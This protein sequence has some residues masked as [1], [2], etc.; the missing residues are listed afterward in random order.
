MNVQLDWKIIDSYFSS[1]INTKY[2]SQHH[3]SSYNTF[4]STKLPYIIKTLNPY[5]IFKNDENGVKY[6]INVYIGGRDGNSIK[7]TKPCNTDHVNNKNNVM[8]PNNARLKDYSYASNLLVDIVIDYI[9]HN[10]DGTQSLLTYE[11]KDLQI[12]NIPVM[13]HSDLC[14]LKNMKSHEMI[15]IGECPYDQGGY[16][17]IDGKEKVIVSQE[18]VSTNK[19]FLQSPQDNVSSETIEDDFSH[20]GIIRCTSKENSLFPKTIKF[21]IYHS[22]ALYGTRFNAICMNVPNIFKEQIPIFIIFRALGIESD[23]EII[24][25]IFL[26]DENIEPRY[27][28]FIRK[29]VHEGSIVTTQQEALQYLAGYCKYNEINF[30]K[31]VLKTDVFPNVGHSFKNKAV[32]LGYLVNKMILFALNELSDTNR[33]SYLYKRVD[34]SGILMGN[35]FRDAYNQFRNHVK[36]RIDREFI[37]GS[38]KDMNEFNTIITNSKDSIFDKEIITSFIKKSFKGKWGIRESEGIVQDLNR[39]SFMGYISHIRRVNTPMDRSLKLVTPHRLDASHWG[40]MCPIE[41]PDGENIGLLKHIATSCQISEEVDDEDSIISLLKT[42]NVTLVQDLIPIELYGLT[43]V[44]LNNNWIGV[45]TDAKQLLDIFKALK[46]SGQ[47]SSH[48]S[49]SWN[50]LENEIE[51]FTDAGRC[52][53]PLYIATDDM[54]KKTYDI[55]MNLKKTDRSSDIWSALISHPKSSLNKSTRTTEVSLSPIEFVDCVEMSRS[56]IAMNRNDIIINKPNKY[57]HIEIHPSL[58]LSLNTNI[59]PLAHHNQSIRNVFSNQQ[60]KQAVGVYATNFNHRIDTASYMLHYPQ[61]AL[62]T[63]KYGK[64]AHVDKMPN[65]ENIIIAIATYTGYNQ[66]DSVIINKNSMARGMFNS[67]IYKS[68]IESE[69]SNEMNGEYINFGNPLNLMKKGGNIDVKYAKWDKIDENGIPIL[70]RYITE[71]DAYVGKIKSTIISNDTDETT[72]R[73]RNSNGTVSADTS[74]VSY[75]DKSSIA[76]FTDGGMIDNRIIYKKNDAK[77]IKIRFRKSRE[78]VLGDKFASRHGQKG[79]VGMII[80]QEDMPFTKDGIVPDMIINPHA[81]PSRMTIAH[82]FESVLAKYS[83]VHGD[84]IDGTT[85]ENIDTSSYFEF[86]GKEGY[87]KHGDEILYNGYTG[88]QINTHIF[89]GPTYYTRLKHMVNEKMNYRGGA[90]SASAPITGMTRQPTHGRANKGGLRIGEME[91]NALLAHGIGSFIKESMME[92]SDKYKFAIDKTNGIIGIPHKDGYRSPFDPNVTEF[93]N[94]ETPYAFKLL[95]QE[96]AAIAIKPSLLTDCTQQDEEKND[97]SEDALFSDTNSED[98][99]DIDNNI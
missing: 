87:H 33:D 23:K 45:H 92:R 18:R 62:L 12:G 63:T 43:K 58:C 40:F 75:Q 93:T 97:I 42:H 34:V 96:L 89:F 30:V 15:Q 72:E 76:G 17:I 55:V 51:L 48:S 84:I 44:I 53:R 68:H 57:N 46:Q 83:C 82:L 37:Y 95:I 11:Q 81:F 2:I 31:H 13:L 29:S 8:L 88:E 14:I 36:N 35:A 77:K 32:Y 86:M 60:G 80:P 21:M 78:P 56:H 79:V 10:N 50:I 52:V 1:N 64:Y 24:R 27:I 9:T 67:S 74:T 16:F 3:I 26:K 66:E 49:I 28:N 22:K 98:D 19:L 70:N 65:G 25:Y 91:T 94:V 5:V 90:D 38:W 7:Q 54:Q 61:K 41:S 20:T 85:F 47:I 4:T 59:I 99:N 69:E 6:T 39:L 73:I 71:D